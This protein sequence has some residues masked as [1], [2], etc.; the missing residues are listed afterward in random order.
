[1]TPEDLCNPLKI[2]IM[3]AYGMGCRGDAAEIK[4]IEPVWV[5]PAKGAAF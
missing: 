4:P 2:P 1:M 5:I 3:R